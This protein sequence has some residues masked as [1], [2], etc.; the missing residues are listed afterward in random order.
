MMHGDS[1]PTNQ[2][3][4]TR[5]STMWQQ[6]TSRQEPTAVSLWHAGRRGVGASVKRTPGGPG[7]TAVGTFFGSLVL[8]HCGTGSG[9]VCHL[10]LPCRGTSIYLR[11]GA[12]GFPG[13][14]PIGKRKRVQ[15]KTHTTT[16]NTNNNLLVSCLGLVTLLNW[17]RLRPRLSPNDDITVRT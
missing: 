13:F 7:P 12:A 1:E 9:R 3:L 16:H 2:V 4:M 14:K 5:T 17:H 10:P 8:G 6:A 15:H 11:I